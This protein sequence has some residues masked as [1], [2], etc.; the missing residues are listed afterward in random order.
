MSK[1]A[2]P[3][4]AEALGDNLVVAADTSS[5]PIG[6]PESSWIILDDNDDIPPTGLFVGHNGTGFL[7]ATGVPVFVP[8][9]VLGVLDDAVMAAPV[10]DPSTK[11]VAGWRERPRYSYRRVAAPADAG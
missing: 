7:I 1:T 10:L 9:H 5:A 6:M 8:N 2:P 3:P 11:K 4:P